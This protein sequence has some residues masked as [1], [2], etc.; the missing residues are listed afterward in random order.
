[1]RYTRNKVFQGIVATQG[2]GG[3]GGSPPGELHGG[4]GVTWFPTS[5]A[6]NMT[7]KML[8]GHSVTN[9]SE[10]PAMSIVMA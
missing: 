2:K 3:V 6:H 5:K 4:A 7:S 10:A 9:I 1:M 8:G